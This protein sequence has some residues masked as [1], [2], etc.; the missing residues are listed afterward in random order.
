MVYLGID[1]S[2]AKLD[3]TLLEPIS[4]KRKTKAVSNDKAGFESLSAWL[5]K[6]GVSLGEVHG[7]MEATGVYHEQA[8]PYG[9]LTQGCGYQW[10][11]PPKFGI[12]PEDWQF[13]PRPMERIAWYWRAMAP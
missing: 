6:Q 10:S 8:V 11:I 2:K 1:V 4:D 5:T 13:A 3:C 7:V 12:L 9:W